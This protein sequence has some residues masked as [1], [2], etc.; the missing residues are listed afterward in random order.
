MSGC[1]FLVRRD[2]KLVHGKALSHSHV[3]Y[4]YMVV[5]RSPDPAGDSEENKSQ[6]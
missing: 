5:I 2:I 4:T 1:G 6:Q 3:R